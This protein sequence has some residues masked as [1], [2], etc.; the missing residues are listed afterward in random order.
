MTK[1]KVI[2]FLKLLWHINTTQKVPTYVYISDIFTQY[3]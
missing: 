1:W 3:T 2:D